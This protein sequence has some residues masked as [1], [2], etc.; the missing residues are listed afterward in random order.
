MQAP[1]YGGEVFQKII[2]RLAVLDVVEERL[3]GYE[4][5]AKHRG[6]VHQFR[7]LGDGF[8]HCFF[9]SERGCGLRGK[10]ELA[11]LGHYD[12]QNAVDAG[13]VSGAEF[14]YPVE[15]VGI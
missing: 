3:D 14:S 8:L 4:G 2:Q 10:F 1:G 6:A 11:L 13:R 15:H 12:P 9:V 7:V 5:A